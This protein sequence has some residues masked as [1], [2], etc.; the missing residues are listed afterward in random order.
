MRDGGQGRRALCFSIHAQGPGTTWGL[1]PH[2]VW[3]HLGSGPTWGLDPAGVSRGRALGLGPDG[4]WTLMG[5]QLPRAAP[6][7]GDR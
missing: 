6:T 7:P 2:G 4:V 3:A 1:G 5:R